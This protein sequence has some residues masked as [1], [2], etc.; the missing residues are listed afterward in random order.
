M[1]KCKSF[2]P[3]SEIHNW[4]TNSIKNKIIFSVLFVFLVVYGIII[5]LNYFQ[6]KEDLLQAAKREALSTAQIIAIA[7]YR[8]Y[9]I[10]TDFREIQSYIIGVKRYKQNIVEINII[11]RELIVISSTKENKLLKKMIADEY[12]RSIKYNISFNILIEKPD[13]SFI[14][15]IHPIS[16]SISKEHITRGALE[17][18]ISIKSQLT[19]LSKIK[20]TA[21]ISGIIIIFAIITIIILL[22]SSIIKPLDNLYSGIQDV[23]KGDLNIQIDVKSKDEIGF[24]TSSFNK[25][26]LSVKDSKQ[27][28]EDYSAKLE[29]LRAFQDEMELINE[30][31]LVPVNIPQTEE[32]A[33][34]ANSLNTVIDNLREAFNRERRFIS[35]VAHEL[36]TPV[37]EIRTLTEVALKWPENL[38]EQSQKNYTDILDASRQM[39]IIINNLLIL[40]RYDSGSLQIQKERFTLKPLTVSFWKNYYELAK[41]KKIVLNNKIPA[42]FSLY[43]DKYMFLLIIENLL[44]NALNYS[45]SNSMVDLNVISNDTSFHL[46]V[47]N[48]AEDLSQDDLPLLFERFWCKDQ[49]RMSDSNHSGLGLSLVQSIATFLGYEVKANLSKTKN[50]TITISGIQ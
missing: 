22:S 18:I 15:I 32:I 47:S 16:A 23:N 45:R 46:S 49:S 30:S 29:H 39:Q 31:N 7:I 8:N 19:H 50:L 11:S 36:R 5:S 24:L 40:S 25:M 41:T 12:N 37:S 34:V 35:N 28:I 42:H 10:P 9:E 14:R 6:I 2:K 1:K 21:V 44:T 3:F 27:K 4:L 26:I 38:D 43:T 48:P 33:G 17:T 20:N 13:N